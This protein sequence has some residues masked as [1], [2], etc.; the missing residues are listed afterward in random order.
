VLLFEISFFVPISNI[1]N[2]IACVAL[3]QKIASHVSNDCSQLS[4]NMGLTKMGRQ[5]K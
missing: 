3:L 1:Q 5:T 4:N 2:E